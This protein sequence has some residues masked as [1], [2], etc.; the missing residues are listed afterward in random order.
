MYHVSNKLLN[1]QTL[2]GGG[3]QGR[4]RR[5]DTVPPYIGLMSIVFTII[6]FLRAGENIHTVLEGQKKVYCIYGNKGLEN[7]YR[8]ILVYSVEALIPWAL[9]SEFVLLYSILHIQTLSSQVGQ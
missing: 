1:T 6:Q 5:C 2:E 9:P 3:I 7:T 4:Y 8:P